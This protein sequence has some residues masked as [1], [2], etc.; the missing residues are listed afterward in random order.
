M[1]DGIRGEALSKL[2]R[3][4]DEVSLAIRDEFIDIEIISLVRVRHHWD[5]HDH[6]GNLINESNNIRRGFRD[7]I[8]NHPDLMPALA[9]DEVPVMG[10]M[11]SFPQMEAHGNR[12][13]DEMG[14]NIDQIIDVLPALEEEHVEEII[15][16]ATT[17]IV[18]LYDIIQD[19]REMYRVIR[20]ESDST[21]SSSAG[22][23]SP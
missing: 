20:E 21:S 10:P 4:R 19:M 22:S 15:E 1:A 11:W 23:A 6:V 3:L 8:I 2:M 12:V 5:L 9:Q 16:L 18:L 7:W 13:L 17:A 14:T